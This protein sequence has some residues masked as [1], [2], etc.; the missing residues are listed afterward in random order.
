MIEH[1]GDHPLHGPAGP[2]VAAGGAALG[3]RKVLAGGDEQLRELWLVEEGG[4]GEGLGRECYQLRDCLRGE[5]RG[6]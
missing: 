5:R 1:S 6:R 3:V 4:E 2:L